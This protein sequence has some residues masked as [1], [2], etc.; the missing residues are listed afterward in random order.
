MTY[1]SPIDPVDQVIV[2]LKITSIEVQTTIKNK[3]HLKPLELLY[4]KQYN[5]LVI[6]SSAVTIYP[7]QKC[8]YEINSWI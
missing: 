1:V 5:K 8:V 2:L 7:H 3:T 6:V 4:A